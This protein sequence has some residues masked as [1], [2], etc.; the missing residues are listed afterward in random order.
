MY[1][2]K[3]STYGRDCSHRLKIFLVL[4]FKN[5]FWE[6]LTVMDETCSQFIEMHA[7]LER[8]YSVIVLPKYVLTRLRQ[9]NV[10]SSWPGKQAKLEQV[11]AM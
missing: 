5:G 7:K 10:L 4:A 9:L 11:L 2:V 8:R 3:R 6:S 1:S